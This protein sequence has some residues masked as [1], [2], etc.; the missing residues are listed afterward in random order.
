[1]SKKNLRRASS[2]LVALSGVLLVGLAGQGLAAPAQAAA[3]GGPPVPR[4]I[5]IDRNAIMQRSLAGKDMVTQT[6]NLSKTAETQF[7]TEET[8]LQT[9]ATQLQQQLAIM[10]AD[11]RE[12]R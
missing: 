1:M 7:R 5:V 12:K 10:A 3:N 2:T 6:Q 11:V 4:I 9:E 8:A